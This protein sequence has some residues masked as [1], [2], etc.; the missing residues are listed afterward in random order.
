MVVEVVRFTLK[1]LE[2]ESDYR[3]DGWYDVRLKD[4]YSV[5]LYS[6]QGKL[7]TTDIHV[8]EVIPS[9][10]DQVFIDTLKK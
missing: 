7:Y 4:G 1:F 6:Y 3:K 5:R 2:V 9:L 10:V 8:L